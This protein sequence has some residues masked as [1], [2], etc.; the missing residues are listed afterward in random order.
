MARILKLDIASVKLKFKKNNLLILKWF[1]I[2]LNG[3][4]VSLLVPVGLKRMQAAK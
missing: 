1:Q 2:Y 3:F 4:D